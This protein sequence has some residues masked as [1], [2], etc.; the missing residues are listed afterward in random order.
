MVRFLADSV[1]FSF[2]QILHISSGAQQAFHWAVPDGSASRN[3][4]AGA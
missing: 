1:D 4:T 3:M 2:L